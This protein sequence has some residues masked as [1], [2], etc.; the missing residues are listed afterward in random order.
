MGSTP[1][2]ELLSG[3]GEKPRRQRQHR[4]TRISDRNRLPL[5]RRPAAR[6]DPP[7]CPHAIVRPRLCGNRADEPQ[8]LTDP[9]RPVQKNAP[10][11][12]DLPVRKSLAAGGV[13]LPFFRRPDHRRPDEK[14]MSVPSGPAG[15]GYHGIPGARSWA[16]VATSVRAPVTAGSSDRCEFAAANAGNPGNVRRNR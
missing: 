14:R 11:C 16:P 15:S 1:T 4:R 13:F 6:K 2:P 10:H 3:V 8:A 12:R 5:W 7:K 9:F